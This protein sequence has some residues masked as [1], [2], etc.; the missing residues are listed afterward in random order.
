MRMGAELVQ[1]VATSRAGSQGQCSVTV[2][3]LAGLYLGVSRVG[4]EGS[5]PLF[6]TPAKISVQSKRT[7]FEEVKPVRHSER[8]R[9]HRVGGVTEV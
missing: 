4:R 2:D 8:H 5:F 1:I 6:T 9:E 7:L 3:G